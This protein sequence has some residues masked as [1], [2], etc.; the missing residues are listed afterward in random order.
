ML[1]SFSLLALYRRLTGSSFLP[2]HYPLT[3]KTLLSTPIPTHGS[4]CPMS[5]TS[6]LLRL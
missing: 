6:Q 3:P 1:L 4:P 5:P 2:S